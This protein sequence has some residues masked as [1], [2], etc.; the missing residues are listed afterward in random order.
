MNLA[1]RTA[2]GILALT[3]IA[4]AGLAIVYARSAVDAQM[5]TDALQ[6]LNNGDSGA[7]R[8]VVTLQ[9][10]RPDLGGSQAN[11]ENRSLWGALSIDVNQG[12]RWGWAIDYATVREAEQRALS[13]CG[14]NCRVVMTF[15]NQCAA[16]AADQEKGSTI[17]G[18]GKDSTSAAAK[19]RALNEC[20]NRGGKSCI[21]RVWGCTRR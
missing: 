13:E 4:F 3:A 10:L 2:C 12:Q 17:Y 19:N 5:R 7:T 18:W 9:A 16:Y 8:S 1:K 6:S 20:R 21:V 15:R 11:P 14:S